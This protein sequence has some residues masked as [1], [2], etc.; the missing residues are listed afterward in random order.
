MNTVTKTLS[1]A[2]ES[3]VPTLPPNVDGLDL[4]VT[5]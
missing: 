5:T 3:I 2:V 4:A 1:P